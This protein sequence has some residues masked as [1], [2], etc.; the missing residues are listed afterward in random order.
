MTRI[1]TSPGSLYQSNSLKPNYL[2]RSYF[3]GGY[4][5]YKVTQMYTRRIANNIFKY[6]GVCP[7]INGRLFDLLLHA[8]DLIED[9]YKPYMPEIPGMTFEESLVAIEKARS[10]GFPDRLYY[11]NRGE[12]LSD[13]DYVNQLR[14]RLDHWLELVSP[15]TTYTPHDKEE[16]RKNEKVDVGDVRGILGCDILALVK[17]LTTVGNVM[18]AIES[19]W[20][21]LPVK[22]GISIF[23][24][25]WNRIAQK[26]GVGRKKFLCTDYKKFDSTVHEVFW[27]LVANLFCRLANADDALSQDI[28][29]Q[30]REANYSAIFDGNGVWYMKD[31]GTATG[32]PFT[33]L[34][35][36][37][38][39]LLILIVC[40]L[41]HGKSDEHILNMCRGGQV[42]VY[43]DD[44]L[45]SE[46][47]GI[48]GEELAATA[49]QFGMIIKPET[50]KMVAEP[51]FLG[52]VFKKVGDSYYYYPE[53]P[54][55]WEDSVV[56]KYKSDPEAYLGSLISHMTLHAADLQT[57]MKIRS[58]AAVWVSLW[59][60]VMKPRRDSWESYKK[61]LLYKYEWYL[62]FHQANIFE[63]SN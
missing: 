5:H 25:Y 26:M 27:F 59:D 17:A 13:P 10:P 4:G 31:H 40:C 12:C 33:S 38:V 50:T 24:G 51:T 8:L 41:Q 60:N 14:Y 36:S 15:S 28:Y 53:D 35:N 42:A 9:L 16:I 44:T 7:I 49:S 29:K 6:N 45:A 2:A 56:H 43:G 22:V 46:D 48:S 47:L 3:C 1:G 54:R 37:F 20:F 30:F 34:Y 58:W 62:H 61:M 11:K 19:M 55:K 23:L 32:S 39:N 18:F 63:I 52:G 21:E 57:W